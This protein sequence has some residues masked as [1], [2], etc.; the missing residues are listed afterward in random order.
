MVSDP[1]TMCP[2]GWND[3][4]GGYC[5]NQDDG[6]VISAKYA[7]NDYHRSL[8]PRA[9]QNITENITTV[10]PVVIARVQAAIDAEMENNVIVMT[11]IA[12][13][14]MANAVMKALKEE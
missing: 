1:R 14:R 12:A 10:D 9:P 11:Q 5:K 4:I 13:E 6:K 2:P 8:K 7:W 3:V